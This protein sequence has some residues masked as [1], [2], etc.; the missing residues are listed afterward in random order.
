MNEDRDV[1]VARYGHVAEGSPWVAERAWARGPFATTAATADAFAA[2]V[3]EASE[4]EQVALIR[5]HPDLAGR[6]ARAPELTADSRREQAGAGLDRLA[7]PQL[8]RL[9][10]L[11]AAYRDRFGFPFVIRVSGRDA[12]EIL[13]A[14]QERLRE[15]AA[16]ERRRAVDEITAIMRLRIEA[17]A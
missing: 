1:F 6:A 17:A 15:G 3:R 2:V 5:A 12:D 13:A 14:C 4:D 7:P 10:A 9:R 8:A 16:A 11:T